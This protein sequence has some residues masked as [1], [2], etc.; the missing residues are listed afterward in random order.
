MEIYLKRGG[1][2][3]VVSFVCVGTWGHVAGVYRRECIELC[4]GDT[5]VEDDWSEVRNTGF[6]VCF[7]CHMCN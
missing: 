2:E 6:F 7:F 3:K 1:E 4:N 5:R